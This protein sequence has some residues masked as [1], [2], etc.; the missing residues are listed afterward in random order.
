MRSVLALL[1]LLASIPAEARRIPV[2]GKSGLMLDDRAGRTV[3]RLPAATVPIGRG[4]LCDPCAL[5]SARLIGERPGG[6][7]ILLV[8]Y[9]SRP[10]T[11]DGACGAGEEEVLNVIS[12]R[13]HPR[14]IVGLRLSSCWSSVEGSG[15]PV[16]DKR[17]GLL[18][19]ERWTPESNAEPERL[20]WRIGRDGRVV[21]VRPPARQ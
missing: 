20:H 1:L 15:T 18:T 14:E 9:A 19:A 17:Q 13:P 10:S 21:A 5:R 7:L 8:T 3:L 4:G 16:W 2:E 6:A 12:L 11:P